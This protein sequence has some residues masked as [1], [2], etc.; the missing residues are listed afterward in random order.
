MKN[1]INKVKEKDNIAIFILFFLI[2][3]GI[4]L[5]I[6]IEASDEIWNFQNVYKMYNRFKIYEEINVIIT[7]LFFWITEIIFHILGANLFIFRLCHCVSIS[8]L[9]LYTYKI[10]KK[11]DVPKSLAIFTIL[12][13]IFQEFFALI[14]GCFNYNILALSFCILGIY[15]FIEEKTKKNIIIQAIITILVILTKQNIG[16]YYLLGNII[17]IIF[18]EKALNTKIKEILKYIS[19]IILGGFIVI[20]YLL[21][22]NNLYNFLSYTFGGILEF[23]NENIIFDVPAII[24]MI[25]IISINIIISI[26]FIK[27]GIIT[28]KQKE[29]IKKL[30]IF[31]IVLAGACYPIF[32]WMHIIIGTYLM[33]INIVYMIYMIFDD[34]KEKIK[35]IVAIINILIILIMIGFSSYAMYE[36]IITITSAKYPY[37]WKEPFFGGIISDENYEE[38]LKITQYI[39]ENEKNVIVCSNKAGLYMIPLKRNN[40]DFDLPFKGNFGFEGEKGLI[41][42]IKKIENT[43]FLISNNEKEDIYQESKKIKEYIK[44]N[45]QHVGEI[46]DFDIYE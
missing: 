34:F 39:Q 24:Y 38:N 42:K 15:F 43:Q 11:L 45:K 28:Q 17:Y 7:P 9:C 8:V 18:S 29:N 20:L 27:K 12:I 36:W 13:L 46:G 23:A 22:D 19:I 33:I 30:L 2:S 40:G 32:N 1:I 4:C 31:S 16:A 26:F 6:F 37:S 10:L 5:D 25:G 21:L 35:K 3:L 44:N 14:R 41:E